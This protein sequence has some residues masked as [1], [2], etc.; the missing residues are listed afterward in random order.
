MGVVY[1]AVR[2]SL[3][4][5]V[6]LKV[7]HP[8]FRAREKYLRR[9]HTEARSAACLHH[10]NIVSVFD[11]DL[12]EGVCYY[13]MQY[14]A[15]QSLD[16]VLADVRALRDHKAGIAPSQTL[17]A[18][19]D[20]DNVSMVAALAG[21]GD[22]FAETE[23]WRR[24]IATGLLTGR[25]SPPGHTDSTNEL[26]PQPATACLCGNDPTQPL[27]GQPG[28]AAA[29]FGLDRGGPPEERDSSLATSSSGL[30]GKSE[31]SY[32]REVARIM[33]QAAD[34]LAY[35]HSRGVFHRDIKPPNLI[36][37]PHGNIWV[38]DFG[39]AKFADSDDVLAIA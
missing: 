12:H 7:M 36:L 19:A 27:D 38:T 32:F 17:A 10:S 31:H 25:Y 34:A 39:L 26:G 6:A 13:A 2:E 9:F 4:S 15:G 35:A 5:H 37:D 3:R 30:A 23:P 28:A 29:D 22:N 21:F 11:Y 24:T 18:S 33:M 14:I 1:E 16:R 20:A 8:Q